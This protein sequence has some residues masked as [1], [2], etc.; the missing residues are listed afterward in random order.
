MLLLLGGRFGKMGR[1][2]EVEVIRT[3]TVC[4]VLG[5]GDIPQAM[6]LLGSHVLRR[7]YVSLFLLMVVE[8]C[9]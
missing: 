2:R 5:C 3:L 9:A 8:L 7:G 1:G 6:E 4:L